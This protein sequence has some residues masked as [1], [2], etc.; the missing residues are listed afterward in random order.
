MESIT[1]LVDGVLKRFDEGKEPTVTVTWPN[2]KLNLK[3]ELAEGKDQHR[4]VA[5]D[6]G[7]SAAPF[8]GLDVKVDI[9]PV[10]AKPLDG[11]IISKW[12]IEEAQASLKKGIGSEKGLYSLQGEVSVI[13]TGKASL[14]CETHFKGDFSNN[15]NRIE[16][17]SGKPVEGKIEFSAEGKVDVKG[18]L[19]KIK[20]ELVAGIGIKSGITLSVDIDKDEKG[21]YWQ[22]QA[23]FNG[24]KVYITKY[25]KVEEDVG[26]E[27][28]Y[29]GMGQTASQSNLTIKETEEY[30]WIKE[31]KLNTNKRYFIEC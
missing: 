17:V 16:K 19:L 5:F 4:V 12:L 26:G 6:F 28:G 23:R 18:H 7:I 1:N 8:F 30:V 20:V 21:Y 3:T 15:N 24:V 13:M 2:L 11:G 10:L 22:P 29:F 31:K 14:G 27:N 9:L 25:V